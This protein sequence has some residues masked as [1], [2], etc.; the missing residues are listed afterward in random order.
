M[1]VQLEISLVV[2]MIVLI[3][4]V[5]Q[6]LLHKNFDSLMELFCKK[7]VVGVFDQA[8]DVVVVMV[9]LLQ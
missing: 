5:K 7:V 8:P 3:I 4:L 6:I 1:E 9:L 2:K